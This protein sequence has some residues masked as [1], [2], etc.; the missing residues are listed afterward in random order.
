VNSVDYVIRLVVAVGI[1]V[2]IAEFLFILAQA[3]K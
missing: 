2:S 1:V 3:I